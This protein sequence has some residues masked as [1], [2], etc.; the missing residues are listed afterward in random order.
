M[1]AK[2]VFRPA[3]MHPPIHRLHIP[4]LSMILRLVAVHAILAARGLDFA[5]SRAIR[6]DFG[7]GEVD[8]FGAF[9]AAGIS[10]RIPRACIT[11]SA[12]SLASHGQ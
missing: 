4:Q 5:V 12:S 2:E 6:T 9:D 7:E 3:L 11:T 10:H 8:E 1:V